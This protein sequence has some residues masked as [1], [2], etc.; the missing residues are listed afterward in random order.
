MARKKLRSV[1]KKERA[2]RSDV[3][4]YEM[5]LTFSNRHFYEFIVKNRVEYRD[6][7]IYWKQGDAAL[8]AVIR[9]IFGVEPAVP[10]EIEAAQ[11]LG[12]PIT[13]NRLRPP[14]STF[15]SIP[16]SFKMRHKEDDFRELSVCH[17][18][19][20]LQLVEFY[21][22]YKDLIVYHCGTSPFSIRRPCR[23]ARTTFHKDKTHYAGP[24]SDSVGV[25]VYEEEY[26][27]LKSFFVYE[28][29]SIIFKFYESPQFHRCE[30]K[31]NKLAKL[32]ISRC[33]DSIY[34]HSL[35][36]ALLGKEPV[37]GHLAKCK[38]TFAGR[39]DRFMQQTN[40]NET[41]G[42]I[43]GPEFS[44]IFAELILQS[45]DRALCSDLQEKEHHHK[46]DYEIL[47]YVD[48]YFVFYNKED[49]KTAAIQALRMRLKEFKLSLNSDKAEEYGKPIITDISRAKL[50]ISKLLT[51]ELA[52]KTEWVEPPG[53][54]GGGATAPRRKKGSIQIEPHALI[55]QF[56]TILR[57]CGVEYKDI[58]VLALSIIEKQTKQIISTH[59][60]LDKDAGA[61]KKLAEAIGGICNFAFFIYSVAPRVNSTIWLSRILLTVTTYLK[62]STIPSHL[63]HPVFKL[64][65]D[66]ASLILKKDASP[67]YTPVE[68]LYLLIPLAELGRDYWLD[69]E[70]LAASFG[71]HLRESSRR[72]RPRA[73][74]NYISFVVLL[75]YMR[76]KKK[77]DRLRNLIEKEL[78][79]KFHAKGAALRK[80]TELTLLL[81][82]ALSCPHLGRST[83]RQ[84]LAVYGVVD[85]ALQDAIIRKRRFWFTKWSAF[86]FAKELDAKRSQEV[87]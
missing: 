71:I 14:E 52:Y 38:S 48:D 27:S 56:K 20:Q 10:T 59:K 86:D 7:A 32:D 5:P 42:I 49:T 61:E 84:L 29:Y 11:I 30:Q 2:I 74:L 58:L 77:Y 76:D 60:F 19:N 15:I 63:R 73:P 6:G 24:S 50:R 3:L 62:D 18:R 17:P 53:S 28:N 68:T 57:E 41:N 46:T 65:F 81:F 31:Y 40:Y 35:A 64:I 34:T 79:A 55:T 54:D 47:R 45:V 75:F 67:D 1:H 4:P 80:D 44:R 8:E 21:D 36:W 66:N 22:T 13:L 12:R 72:N 69:S 37:K 70:I 78:L 87:Y 39:F 25:E 16:F 33:F 26:E 83:K 82:D 85:R 51:E 43:I 23:V 9:L